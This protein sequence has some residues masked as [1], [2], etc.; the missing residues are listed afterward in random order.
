MFGKDIME[1]SQTIDL[2]RANSALVNGTNRDPWLISM[3]W[4]FPFAFTFPTDLGFKIIPKYDLTPI[5]EV[6]QKPN[7][8]NL[9]EETFSFQLS[10][11]F[12]KFRF[13]IWMEFLPY[14]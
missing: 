4:I 6:H 7:L 14:F 12:F 11:F 8:E 10:E 13:Y 1:I 5:F 2:I 3:P 9:P